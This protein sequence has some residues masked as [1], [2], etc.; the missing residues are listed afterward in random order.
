MGIRCFVAVDVRLEGEG[1]EAYRNVRRS[2]EAELRVKPVEEENLHL[3]LRF[4]GEVEEGV[5]RRVG[6][7]LRGIRY[8][9]FS[10]TLRGLG[11]FPSPGNPR[12]I[13][14][15]VEEGGEELRG[16]RDE[17]ERALRG[18][19]PREEESFVAHLTIARVKE[20]ARGAIEILKEYGDYE[21]G[22]VDV[23]E[24][25]LKRSVLTRKGPIYTD[26]EVYPLVEGGG[27]NRGG[28][29]EAQAPRGGAQEGGRGS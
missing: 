22:K 29:G 3:T 8:P 11:A 1:L 24:F 16:L 20:R 5:V 10:V 12:V 28:Q 26:I 19:V 6:E 7:A 18:I 4:L 2:L 21:F 9:R 23:N 27:G 25:K 17:I 13:W 14:I 15:G